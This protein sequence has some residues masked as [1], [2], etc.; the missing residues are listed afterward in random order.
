MAMNHHEHESSDEDTELLACGRDLAAVW[1]QAT[2]TRADPHTS[3]CV[4]CQEAL[5]DLERLRAAVLPP[6]PDGPTDP[7]DTSSLARRVM[8]LV[9]L[10]LRPG[11]NL[12]LG[13]LEEDS[14]IYESVAARIL[15]AAA[16][17]VPGVRA[18]SC[19]IVPPDGP[20]VARRG[21]VTVHLK[22][23]AEYGRDL[24]ALSEAVRSTTARAAHER[25]GL[26]VSALDA[27]VSDLHDPPDRPQEPTV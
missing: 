15:R 19:R 12:P 23:T 10:E 5:A 9:R 3:S 22:I 1:E 16:E 2:H 27:T 17:E 6:M 20:G 4:N 11:R 7:S 24:Q 14:W 26:T 8:D 21:P 18:G 25:I 13:E